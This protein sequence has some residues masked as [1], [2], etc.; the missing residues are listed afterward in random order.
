MLGRANGREHSRIASHRYYGSGE[1]VV[2][3][4]GREP[5]VWHQCVPCVLPPPDPDVLVSCP[6]NAAD[7]IFDWDLTKLAW[8]NIKWVV[9]SR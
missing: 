4:E 6:G 8:L 7:G 2:A 5:S 1:T 3:Q 9:F